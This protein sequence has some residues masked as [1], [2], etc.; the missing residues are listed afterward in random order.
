M[1]A[2]AMTLV[3]LVST[4]VL[5]YQYWSGSLLAEEA[6]SPAQGGEASAT[7]AIVPSATMRVDHAA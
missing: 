7:E 2:V 1:F 5:L 6:P 4:A 3:I